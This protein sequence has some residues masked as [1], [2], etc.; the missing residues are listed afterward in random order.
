MSRLLLRKRKLRH[1]GEI[2]SQKGHF[3]SEW[4]TQTAWFR[5]PRLRGSGHPGFITAPLP[6][7]ASCHSGDHV[8]SR[9]RVG[10]NLNQKSLGKGLHIHRH[11]VQATHWTC[12]ISRL[13]EPMQVLWSKLGQAG[14]ESV[15]S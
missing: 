8:L 13:R 2:S 1:T 3:E 11:S 5:A 12:R 15:S 10:V 14:V 7:T 9:P 6:D 4:G